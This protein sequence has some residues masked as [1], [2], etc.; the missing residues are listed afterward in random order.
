MT[1]N[2]FKTNSLAIFQFEQEAGD[3]LFAV[4]LV[5]RMATS[6]SLL[7]VM[8]TLIILSV[9]WFRQRSAWAWFQIQLGFALLPLSSA[10]LRSPEHAV[11]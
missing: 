2:N 6:S 4:W 9:R 10:Y 8:V 11:S 3:P 7:I 5:V 1:E